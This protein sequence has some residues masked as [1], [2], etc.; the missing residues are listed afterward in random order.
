M[1]AF[2]IENI[3]FRKTTSLRNEDVWEIVK[4]EKNPYY[5]KEKEYV[6]DEGE[7]FYHPRNSKNVHIAKSLF[8]TPETCYTLGWIEGKWDPDESRFD[9]E[10]DF[11]SCGVRPFLLTGK[12]EKIFW[13]VV[14]QVYINFGYDVWKLPD[15]K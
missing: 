7:D 6:L 3:E 1:E 5:G 13:E 9:E 14:R 12:E 10:P 15:G 11:R 8:H 2:R 4:W